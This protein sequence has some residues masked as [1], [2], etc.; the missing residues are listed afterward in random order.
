MDDQKI[1]LAIN[2]I[3]QAFYTVMRLLGPKVSEL[4]E[5]FDLT[6][7]QFFLLSII[8]KDDR[9]TPS[10]LAQQLRVKP[11]AVTAMIDRLAKNEFVIRERDETDRR[12]IYITMS[13][14]GREALKHAMETRDQVIAKYL[15]QFT[16]Q[17]YKHFIYGFQKLERLIKED[18]E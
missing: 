2:Q 17:E 13:A 15:S 5:R 7:D 8:C 4:L 18:M 12:V 14:K 1:R 11:S 9:V 6:K 16:E 3:D 10:F